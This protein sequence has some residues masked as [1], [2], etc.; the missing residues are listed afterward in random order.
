MTVGS[1]TVSGADG[2]AIDVNSATASIVNVLAGGTVQ[3]TGT[4]ATNRA[5]EITGSATNISVAGSVIGK[6]GNAIQFAPGAFQDLLE[7]L[8]T[9][10]ITGTVFADAG[11]DTL[12]F[13]GPGNGSFDLS[14]IDTG[15]NTQQ[16]RQFEVFEVNGGVWTFSN[17]TTAS[18]V[19]NGGTITGNASFGGL[20]INNGAILAP[21]VGQ[22]TMN[23]TGNLAFNTGGILNVDLAPGGTSDLIDV[24]GTT[25]I[26]G[27]TVLNATLNP[28]VIPTTRTVWTV[29]DA[30]GGVT[31]QFGSVTDNLP[32]IDLAAVYN[33]TNVQLVFDKSR[34][35][36]PRKKSIPLP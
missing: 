36:P 31:G 9:F 13:N 28:L 8:P 27:G 7:L 32:D 26:A 33:P 25:T 5:I 16:Y 24:T 21:G 29:I 34:R 3:G 20:T 10:N 12:R 1:G 2:I 14:T 6:S 18:F 19:G 35:Q 15:A 30:T 4:M 11:T 17:A 22:G 23:V